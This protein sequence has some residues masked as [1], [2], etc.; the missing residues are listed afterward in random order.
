MLRM[1]LSTLPA[2][3]TWLPV[4]SA[5]TVTPALALVALPK[6]SVITATAAVLPFALATLAT[7]AALTTRVLRLA[8]NLV[9]LLAATPTASG[10]ERWRFGGARRR[11]PIGIAGSRRGWFGPH[12]G[13]SRRC[14]WSHVSGFRLGAGDDLCF[15]GARAPGQ[16]GGFLG[17]ACVCVRASI[18]I[19]AVFRGHIYGIS[20]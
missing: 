12:W 15:D 13:G 19:V 20:Y 7:L 5:T 18:G 2:S 17:R 6:T 10:F 4:A 14:H 11:R 8:A 3:T 9:L 16:A 1:R